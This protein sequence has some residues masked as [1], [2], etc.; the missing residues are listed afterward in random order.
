MDPNGF[1]RELVDIP[2]GLLQNPAKALVTSW[3]QRA[4]EAL[5]RIAPKHPLL[6]HCS[7]VPGVHTGVIGSEKE[8]RDT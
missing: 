4:A 3:N 5:D 1:L 6:T 2:G 8:K 7:T